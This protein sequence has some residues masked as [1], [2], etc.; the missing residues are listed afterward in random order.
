[1]G[2]YILEMENISKIFPGVKALSDVNFKVKTGEIHC[3]VGENGAGKSTLMKVLSGVYPYGTYEGNIILNDKEQ[4]YKGIADSEAAGIAIIYQELAL[5]PELSVYENIYFGHEIKKGMT[6]DWNETIVK[7]E[8]M[9][10]QVGLD[11]NPAMKVTNL[12]VGKQQ[13]VEIAKALSKNVRLLILDEPTAALNEDDSA[14]LLDL[15]RGLKKQGV[16][17]IMISHKLKEIVSIADIWWEGKSIIST[18]NVKILKSE[19][20]VLKLKI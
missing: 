8:E 10:R 5:I 17:S 18:Q 20:Y 1:M 11:I 7:A 2:E 3:L 12:S 9:L 13:L 15:L 16:T 19:R 14:N 4:K 6:V